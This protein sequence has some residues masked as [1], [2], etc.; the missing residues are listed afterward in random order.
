MK[1]TPPYPLV[2]AALRHY[3]GVMDRI[4]VPLLVLIFS[5]ILAA[6]GVTRIE[7]SPTQITH[8]ILVIHSYNTD[9]QWT[10][11]IDQTMRETI[12][13]GQEERVVVHSE[14]LDSKYHNSADYF[15]AAARHLIEK[16]AGWKFDVIVAADNHA[17]EF[18]RLHREEIV[19]PIPVIFTGINS[20][21]PLLVEGL[22]NVSG[23]VEELD[24]RSTFELAHNLREG[25]T[26]WILGDGTVT[27]QRNVPLIRRSLREIGSDRNIRLYPAIDVYGVQHIAD[28]V[29]PDDIVFLAASILDENGEVLPFDA[30]GA[31]VSRLMPTPVF[32]VWD[33]F[34]GTGT[35]GGKLASGREQGRAAGAI[36]RRI[37]LGTET[38]DIPVLTSSPN[39]WIFDA[40]VL[41]RF[42]IDRHDLPPGATFVNEETTI[43]NLYRVEILVTAGVFTVLLVLVTLLGVNIR[44]RSLVTAQL[45][46]SL[47][48]KEVLLK[49]IHHRVKNNLQ[50]I[51]SILNMQSAG[52]TDT[53][54]R[55]YFRDC[56][57]RVHSMAL[58]HE[59]LYQSSTLAHIS[60][61]AYIEDLVSSLFGSMNAA[62]HR[63]S[64]HHDIEDIA[65]DL[66]NAIPVGLIVNELISNVLKYAYPDDRSGT[67][68]LTF[69][70]NYDH[71]YRLVVHDDGVGFPPKITEELQRKRLDTLG[72]HLIDALAQQLGGT[73]TFRN[74][75][76]GAEVELIF[77]RARDSR[78][79]S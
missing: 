73:I 27:L 69:V 13:A 17:L 23:V 9:F 2:K 1:V 59:Q 40:Q 62:G 55:A 79:G 47:T 74:R 77:P 78:N 68:G 3:N 76:T 46:E 30:A 71:Q 6:P 16:Y 21:E 50:V 61:A 38:I 54:T 67:I 72:V 5:M 8:R 10:R 39:R 51:S 48:E 25:E 45:R 52:I 15:D 42:D 41:K 66:D 53:T 33:F 44:R 19:G 56:E 22:R 29:Q 18:V 37:L 36:I 63:I 4:G 32:V 70:R 14:F 11:D 64:I 43:W 7:A 35:L 60:M 34:V 65:M 75:P 26:V 12:R 57:T 31:I 28:K 24:Y 49:E 58:V 20:Y